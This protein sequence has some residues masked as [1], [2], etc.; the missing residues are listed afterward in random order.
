MV[1]FY[2]E[3]GVERE[4]D[5][6]LNQG[7]VVDMAEWTSVKHLYKVKQ[8]D[9]VTEENEGVRERSQNVLPMILSCCL[10]LVA[11]QFLSSC[12]VL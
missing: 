9:L 4:V 10:T 2:A 1:S 6:H 8:K 7:I 5:G 11:P 3:K 12:P